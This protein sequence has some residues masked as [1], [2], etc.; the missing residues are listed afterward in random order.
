[1]TNM[2]CKFVKRGDLKKKKFQELFLLF[3][4]PFAK[5]PVQY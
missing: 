1:M 4:Q 5:I 3:I 2:S